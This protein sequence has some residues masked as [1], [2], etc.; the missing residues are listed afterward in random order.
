[1]PD[2]EISVPLVVFVVVLSAKWDAT[3]I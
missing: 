3:E 2:Q 1:M